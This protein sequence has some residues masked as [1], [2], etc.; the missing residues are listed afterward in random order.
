MSAQALLA[1]NIR[2]IMDEKKLTQNDVA[3]A[4]GISQPTVSA[5]LNM[6]KFVQVDSLDGL[7]RGLGVTLGTLF[8]LDESSLSPTDAEFMV[9][10]LSLPEQG[11]EQ[12][13]RVAQMES[14]Y[15]PR[16]QPDK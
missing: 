2:R 6:A 1:K 7:A 9:L 10:Y 13:R 11:Q 3:K 8:S 4:G 14:R 5:A 12:V 16:T 15:S